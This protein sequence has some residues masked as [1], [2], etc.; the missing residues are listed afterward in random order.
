[1]YYRALTL[2][3]QVLRVQMYGILRVNPNFMAQNCVENFRVKLYT[4]DYERF[5]YKEN[6]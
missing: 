4:V 5:R 1:M 3:W 2:H 6:T